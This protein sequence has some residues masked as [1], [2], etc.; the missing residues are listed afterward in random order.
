MQITITIDTDNDAFQPDPWPE[1]SRILR[2]LS[3]DAAEGPRYL[4]QPRD[5]NGN[6][7]GDVHIRRD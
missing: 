3:D 2:E 5:R 1:V 4:D 6:T 7:C